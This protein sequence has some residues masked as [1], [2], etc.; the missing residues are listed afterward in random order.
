MNQQFPST[1]QKN[2]KSLYIKSLYNA[3]M[4]AAAGF[5]MAGIAGFIYTKELAEFLAMDTDIIQYISTGLMVAAVG[6][7]IAGNFLIKGR[8]NNDKPD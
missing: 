1:T 3:I 2:I 4:I 6:D 8:I 7:A 5:L